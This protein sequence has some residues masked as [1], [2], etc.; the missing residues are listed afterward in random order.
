MRLDPEIVPLEP[1]MTLG[2]VFCIVAFSAGLRVIQH[3]K[4]MDLPEIGPVGF[5]NVA[6][7]IIRDAQIR[8]DAAALV[9]IEAELLVVTV[10]TVLPRSPGEKTVLPHL[11]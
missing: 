11:I 1:G 3:L 6:G 9:A 5:R 10:N 7:D 8:R 4:G 2:A